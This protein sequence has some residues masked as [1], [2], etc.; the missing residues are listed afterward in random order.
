MGDSQPH[1]NE[2]HGHHQG[3]VANV[4][5]ENQPVTPQMAHV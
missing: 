2:P 4:G 5:P 3:L 1:P